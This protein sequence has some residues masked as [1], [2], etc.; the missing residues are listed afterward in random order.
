MDATRTRRISRVCAGLETLGNVGF[1]T[2]KSIQVFSMKGVF[3]RSFS[4]GNMKP[5]AMCMG[6]NDTLWVVSYSSYRHAIYQYS[7]EGR[8]LATF[9]CSSPGIYGIAWHEPSERIILTLA[10]SRQ[11][12]IEV[13]W[14]NPTYTQE[15]ATCNV[16]STFGSHGGQSVT[17][18][19]K[20]NIF[21]ADQSNPRILK[22]NK[23]GV[24]VSSFGRKGRA[25][26]PYSP[27]GICVDSLG[28]VIVADFV[29]NCVEMFTAEGEYIRT[30]AY[31]RKPV[32]VASGG[33]GQLVVSNQGHLLIIFPKY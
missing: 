20:G 2:V 19:Q 16:I 27:Y 33:E 13:A 10:I 30:I 32:H 14:L 4:I 3:L 12:H 18:D 17:V 15:S 1:H 8:V 21:V 26:N 7:K 31:I 9:T 29:N 23:K 25:R 22:Y 24:Y 6:N 11:D 28:R 5:R